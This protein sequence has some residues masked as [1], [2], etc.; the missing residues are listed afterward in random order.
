M[1]NLNETFISILAEFL[2]CSTH[3]LL[4]SL[5]I[6]PDSMFEKRLQYGINIWY[7]RHPE[8]YTYIKRVVKNTIPL[9]HTVSPPSLTLPYCAN[10][11][12]SRIIFSYYPSTLYSIC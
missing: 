4:K 7:C 12:H 3:I 6:Y 8:V 10:V 5:K 9:I 11:L 1:E 2:E